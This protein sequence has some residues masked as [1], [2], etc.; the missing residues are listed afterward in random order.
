MLGLDPKVD[1]DSI[2]IEGSGPATIT[3]IQTD[4]ISRGVTFEDVYGETDSSSEE[5]DSYEPVSLGPLRWQRMQAEARLGNARSSETTAM[6]VLHFLDL[7]GANMTPKDAENNSLQG[8]LEQYAERRATENT[9]YQQAI[10]EIAEAEQIL[11]SLTKSIAKLETQSRKAQDKTKRQRAQKKAPELRKRKEQRRFWATS[12]S[13]VT[14]LLDSQSSPTPGSSRRSSLSLVERT[15]DADVEDREVTL[16]LS[17]V[18]PGAKWVSRYELSINTPAPTPTA[19][20]TY[21]AEFQNQSSET[22]SNARVTLSTSQTSLFAGLHENIPSLRA[23]HVKLTTAQDDS[24]EQPAWEN[25]IH[26][27]PE[28]PKPANNMGPVDYQMEMMRLEQQNKRRLMMARQQQQQQSRP[29]PAQP[30][31]PASNM[32]SISSPMQPHLA[33]QQLQ[34]QMMRQAQQ[35]QQAQQRETMP[36][37]GQVQTQELPSFT[38]NMREISEPSTPNDN[39]NDDDEQD[40]SPPSL[41]YQDSTRQEYGMTTTYDLPGQRTLAPSSVNRRHALAKLDYKSVTLLHVIIP[42]HRAVAFLRAHI[43]NTSSIQILRGRVGLTVDG[44]FLGT[45]TMPN[46][47]PNDSF[48]LSLGVDPSIMVTYAKPTVRR[49]TSGLFVKEDTAVFRRSVWVKNTK[50]TMANIAV[51]DQVPVSHDEK[52]QMAILEPRGLAKEGDKVTVDMDS[53]GQC[54]VIMGKD[55]ELRWMVNLGAGKSVRLV[56]EYEMKA[57]RGHHVSVS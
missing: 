3:D 45:S 42:K 21:G 32:D 20:L 43:R 46:C 24:N 10:V 15:S 14:V 48:E 16:R 39:I 7:Y 51:L 23:W 44:A 6:Q 11:R 56:L 47:S 17:Y 28:M 55:G 31:L 1:V 13:Q 8:F 37:Q 57:P 30:V 41:E 18:V 19:Q 27:A 54:V 29:Q 35:A 38:R 49:E 40:P 5:A 4:I 50:S 52:L 9:R 33:Q 26:S 25:I 34:Q 36:Q 53:N 12:V 22:W 2:R